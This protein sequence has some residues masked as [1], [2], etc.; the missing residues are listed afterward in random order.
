MSA[1]EWI[2]QWLN[3]GDEDDLFLVREL[4]YLGDSD[5]KIMSF[6]KGL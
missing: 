6:L 4:R 3:E 1:T 5:E 2:Q